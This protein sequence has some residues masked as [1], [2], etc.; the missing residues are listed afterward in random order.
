MT[1]EQ[2]VVSVQ[3]VPQISLCA[4]AVMFEPDLLHGHPQIPGQS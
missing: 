2:D 3:P 4:R 1:I